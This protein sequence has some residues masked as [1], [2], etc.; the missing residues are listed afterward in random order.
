MIIA[1]SEIVAAQFDRCPGQVVIVY[2]PIGERYG[3]GDGA[4]CAT[5]SGS[6]PRRRCLVSVGYVTEGRGQDTLVR[7]MP[8]ILG[9]CPRPAT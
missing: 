7:A 9:A 8:A 5:G 6:R 3:E 1:C 4:R 2:P